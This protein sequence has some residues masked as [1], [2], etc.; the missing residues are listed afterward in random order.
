[1][2][3][4][5][6]MS[7]VAHPHD[8]TSLS[9][10]GEGNPEPAVTWMNPRAV[11]AVRE[12][13]TKREVGVIP[14]T[15]VPATAETEGGWWAPGPG[16]DGESVYGGQSFSLG[17]RKN[18]GVGGGDGYDTAWSPLDCAR[19]NGCGGKLPVMC[20]LPRQERKKRD[21]DNARGRDGDHGTQNRVNV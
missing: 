4:D 13:G 18:S 17:R 19:K 15:R 3:G 2:C 6:W 9:L 16:R 12:S 11:R 1:M 20:M 21:E 14:L 10:T 8:R 5:G 7:Q